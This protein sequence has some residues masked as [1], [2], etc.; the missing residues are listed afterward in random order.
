MLTSLT[1]QLSG[2]D[3][4]ERELLS[5]PNTG[6]SEDKEPWSEDEVNDKHQ[7]L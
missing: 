5:D 3:M 4:R 7:T 1:S 2:R 6:K